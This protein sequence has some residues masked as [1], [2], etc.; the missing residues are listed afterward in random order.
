[1]E[2]RKTLAS[3]VLA[4]FLSLGLTTRAN[5]QDRNYYAIP[6]GTSLFYRLNS[7]KNWESTCLNDL[8]SEGLSNNIASADFSPDGKLY[9][10]DNTDLL[11]AEINH[12]NGAVT[13]TTPFPNTTEAIAFDSN[14]LLYYINSP[15][16]QPNCDDLYSFNI[17]TQENI[18]IGSITY[19][20]ICFDGQQG[21]YG[22]S[23]IYGIDFAS[24]GQ[25]YG[26][27]SRAFIDPSEEPPHLLNIN[28]TTGDA[29][30]VCNIPPADITTGFNNLDI[31]ENGTFIFITNNN[32]VYSIN[33][34]NQPCETQ[35]AT[36]PF[37]CLSVDFSG[38]ASELA[39]QQPTGITG[40]F[41]CDN[42]VDLSDFA[43]FAVCFGASGTYIPPGCPPPLDCNP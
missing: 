11:L 26:L 24:D 38:L 8:S 4:T 25:L 34:L 10:V 7:L 3:I 20:N 22:F 37:H 29:T 18:R 15:T 39:A 23:G 13:S 19:Q 12:L 32:N 43:T 33:P 9:V 42:R 21:I 31:D 16:I 6:S 17:N 30:V 41:N 14:G 28:K 35:L 40:D 5:A 1:M 36:D 27:G 2:S